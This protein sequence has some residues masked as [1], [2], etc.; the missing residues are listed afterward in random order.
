MFTRT[1]AFAVALAVC[2]SSLPAFAQINPSHLTGT[3]KD[4]QGAVLPG[5]TVTATSP[6]L[7]GTQAVVTEA[8]GSYRFA[9]LPSGTYVV[10]FELQ[11]FQ[12]MKRDN[13]VLGVGQTLTIDATLQIATLQ[14]TVTVT[15]ESPVVDTQSTAV[16]Y[17][18]TTAQLV[19]VP[20]S[21]DLWGALAQTPGVRM[22]GVDVGGS[23]KSQQSG[24]EA[25]GIRNQARV[26]TDGVDTT[27]GS[28]ARASTRT[29][30]R[31]TKS[32]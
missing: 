17:V 2:L 19:G 26:I 10:T 18:Q 13:I 23:H 9:S 3:V 16:G 28:A 1:R 27:E 15:S 7:L 29:T 8:G 25:F 6:A 11:G 12:T 31:R 32:R 5:V 30:S 20:S 24:Y 21:T 22:Q 14:E 4:A